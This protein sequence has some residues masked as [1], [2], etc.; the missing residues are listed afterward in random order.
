MFNNKSSTKLY[1]IT[2]PKISL[3]KFAISLDEVLKTSLVSCLQL[4]LKDV[5]DKAVSV[6]EETKI[7]AKNLTISNAWIGIASKDSSDVIIE[8]INVS[9]CGLYDFAAYQKKSYFSGASMKVINSKACNKSLSQQGSKLVINGNKIE[10]K[11]INIKKE[12]YN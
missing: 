1:L 8:N 6:G 12:L 4:R 5:K 9:N 2:P 7:N 11:K 10:E 3:N